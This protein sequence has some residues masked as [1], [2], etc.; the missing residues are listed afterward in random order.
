ME[1]K[2]KEEQTRPKVSRR[3]GKIK[4]REELSKIE[5]KK[6]IEKINETK[7]SFSLKR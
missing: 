1:L 4:I 5:A 6:T 2:K 3:K 7:S